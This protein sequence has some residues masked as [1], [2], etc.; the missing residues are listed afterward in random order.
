MVN[1]MQNSTRTI[2][3]T[4]QRLQDYRL[5]RAHSLGRASG[6]YL[7][8][9]VQRRTQCLVKVWETHLEAALVS[10]FLT[11]TRALS[12]LHHP[13]ILPVRDA[14][15]DGLIPFVV[16]DYVPYITLRLRGSRGK[17]Q[18]LANLLPFLGSIAGALQYAHTRGIL[19]KHVQPAHILLDSNQ[20]VLLS[21]FGIDAVDHN[22]RQPLLLTKDDAAE[23]LGYLAPEQIEGKAFPASDQY[24]L[25]VVIYE[26]LSGTI[27]FR[28]SYAE[29]A[30]QQRRAKPPSL[31]QNI[32]G[33]AR[34]VE[35]TLFIA[36]A[37]DPARRFP[38]VVRFLEALQEAHGRSAAFVQN[39]MPAPQLYAVQQPLPAWQARTSPPAAGV[40]QAIMAPIVQLSTP[41]TP[42]SVSQAQYT[43]TADP[44]V[45]QPAALVPT[46]KG[47]QKQSI[48]RRAF[49]AGLLG[50]AVIGGGAAWLALGRNLPASLP[51][52][53]GAPGAGTQ[54]PAQLARGNIFTY[55]A[56][57]AR[58]GAVAWSPNGQRIASASDDHLVLICDA[59]KGKTVLTYDG[60]SDAVLTLAWSPD[61]KY[62]ASGGADKTVQVWNAT[63][64]KLITTYTGHSKQVNAVSWSNASNMI[65]SGSDDGT[66][67]VWN[68]LTQEVFFTYTG[69]TAGVLAVAWSPDDSMIASG[70]WDNTVQAIA[71]VASQSFKAGGT[72]FKYEGHAAEIYAVAWSPDGKRLASASGDKLVTVQNGLNGNTIFQYAGH[73]DIVYAVA[74][75]PDGTRLASGSADDTAQVWN[76]HAR[77]SIVRQS[78]FTY[79][80]HNNIVYAVGWSPNSLRLASGS[81]DAT[82]QVWHM[83]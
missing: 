39:G 45:K 64:G 60:H 19:H 83:A 7:G 62:I 71:A 5:V 18:P 2:D 28:G 68:A 31:Y 35:E 26:W 20:R 70:S 76:A 32:P 55:S 14:G 1:G 29:I 11:Q 8:E 42:V 49:V 51:D 73:T 81:A 24:G 16:M 54:S 61:G 41:I 80:G 66:V 50:A 78:V 72:I 37:K 17:P 15:I 82:M 56:H 12:E 47:P 25:A 36:L 67:Q 6:I 58:V 33:I 52:P 77:Q 74:W 59:Q 10:D 75:S 3:R 30:Q 13:N 27:P 40:G 63:T 38:S 53:S 4:G 79:T 22:T 46:R 65:A 44:I 21:D 9:H 57:Q 34:A 23:S 43:P 48:T 69:H